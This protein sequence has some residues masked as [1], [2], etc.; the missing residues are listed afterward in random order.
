MTLSVDVAHLQRVLSPKQLQAIAFCPRRKL[1]LLEGSVS[2]GKTLASLWALLIGIRNAPRN[3]LIVVVAKTMQTAFDNVF[4]LLQSPEL[5]GELAGQTSY[6]R[7]APTARILGRDVVVVGANDAKSEEKIRGKTVALAYVDEA[8]LLPQGFWPMLV[9]RL[10]V[11]GARLIA[12]TNPGPRNH[13][14]RKDW[15]LRP[16]ETEMQTFS[17]RM[18]DNPSLTEAYIASME[19][20]F[21]GVFYD[22]FILG[23]WTNA[24]G[25]VFDMFDPTIHVIPWVNVPR[26]RRI[27]G[28]GLDYGTQNA[29]AA[30]ALGWAEDGKLYLVDEWSHDTKVGQATWTDSQLSSGVRAWLPGPHSP[31]PAEPDPEW[32]FV[33]PAAASFKTQLY[34]DGLRNVANADNDV[35]TGIRTMASLLAQG[36][37]LISDRCEG[38][39][40]EMP[41]YTWSSKAAEKGR[42]EPVKANDHRIDGARYAVQSTRNVWARE[43]LGVA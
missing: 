28:V 18:R 35:L 37:L 30:L 16:D 17:F 10:R 15:I 4:V 42:D 22:R 21:T 6:T 32:L 2:A 1:T 25:A 13:W 31:H 29:T 24:E 14:L 41:G 12:T 3:G 11:P 23:K 40:D 43:L 9:T 33:D 38:L 20:S 27:P 34:Y 5:F 26:L 36:K 8:T 19:R 7:G 39:V